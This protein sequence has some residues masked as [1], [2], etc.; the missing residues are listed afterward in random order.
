VQAVGRHKELVFTEDMLRLTLGSGYS[1]VIYAFLSSHLGVQL[2]RTAGVG[3]K[4]LKLRADLM[5]SLP[6]PS[7]SGK[8][9]ADVNRLMEAA[10]AERAEADAAES[11]AI[12]IIEKEVLPQWLA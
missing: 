9:E 3:T 11:S 10:N 7:I 12:G 5:R 1:N 2:I 4:I 6:V 8:Q